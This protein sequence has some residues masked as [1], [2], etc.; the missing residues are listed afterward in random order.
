MVNSWKQI[1]FSFLMYPT[2]LMLDLRRIIIS[3][4]NIFWLIG[5]AM[6]QSSQ[7][8]R[9]EPCHSTNYCWQQ[10]E[11]SIHVAYYRVRNCNAKIHSIRSH[12]WNNHSKRTIWR[13]PQKT[14]NRKI[15]QII[16]TASSV[17]SSTNWSKRMTFF[18]KSCTSENKR[19]LLTQCSVGFPIH[20]KQRGSESRIRILEHFLMDSHWD[21]ESFFRRIWILRFCFPTKSNSFT[22]ILCRL[23]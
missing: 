19:I 22:K 1:L 10:W 17:R 2:Q 11:D 8:C 7:W 3:A 6:S 15:S 16:H 4:P 18:P 20:S 12:H 23:F 14:K 9:N 5:L 13:L 21:S